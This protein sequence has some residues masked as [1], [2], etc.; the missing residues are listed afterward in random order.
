VKLNIEMTMANLI[1]RI[2]VSTSRR[3]GQVSFAEEFNI[4]SNASTSGKKSTVKRSSIHEL[5]G[6]VS[7]NRE[8]KDT[9]PGSFTPTGT[10]IK[11]T[12]SITVTS[13][14]SHEYANIEPS[15]SSLFRRG[16]EVEIT[17]N[18]YETNDD[19][20]KANVPGIIVEEVMVGTPRSKSIDSSVKS[21]DVA[22]R[23]T[24]DSDDEAALVG[25][26]RGWG[27]GPT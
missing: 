27:R 10:Q 2:A 20:F 14:P 16:S 24:E 19:S 8:A 17:G 7:Y 22:K 4:S 21:A 26:G 11:T 13:Q 12:Q 6:I 25:R 1:K 23:G 3:T 9:R 15:K 18:A 5:A